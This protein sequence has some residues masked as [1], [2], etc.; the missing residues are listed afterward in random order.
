MRIALLIYGKLD[1]LSGGYL[2]DRALVASLRTAGD[3]VEIISVPRRSY[4]RSLGDNFSPALHRR[5]LELDADILLQDELN[6][7]S[8]FLLN[9]RVRKQI[10]YPIASIVHLLTSCVNHP[11]WQTSVYAQLEQ[12]YLST[13]DGLICN[14]ATT[15]REAE[16]LLRAAQS[17]KPTSIVAYPGSDRL[18]PQISEAE[19]KKRARESPL[20]VVFLGNV[21]PRK[22]LHL[23]LNALETVPSDLWSLTVIGNTGADPS[24]V[25]AI[26][27]QIAWAG[28]GANARFTGVVSDEDLSKHL[29]A[30][31]VF[32]MPSSCEGYGIAYAEAMGFGLPA[33]GTTAGAAA[34]I[35]THGRDGFLIH[36]DDACMLADYLAELICDRQR[37]LEM[38]CAAL[39]RFESLPTW[40]ASMHA[41]RDFLT[42]LVGATAL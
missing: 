2:Y 34:E 29:A 12:R 38:S 26:S 24:Y 14:S 11:A 16:R 31:H 32:V 9:R 23:V 28:L 15:G 33:V 20:R 8:L 22:G 30:S 18:N 17:P 36:A 39:N 25:R 7:P 40:Q 1:T 6:H 41:I 3:S 5:L 4:L 10:N 13:V 19:L 37:L 35:I 27:R 21:I 42:E